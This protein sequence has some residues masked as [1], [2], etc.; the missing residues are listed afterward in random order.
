MLSEPSSILSS[1]SFR[2]LVGPERQEFAIHLEL[3]ASQSEVLD[4]LV[5]GNMKEAIA[6]CTTWENVDVQTFIRFG[7]Y[8]YTG[9]YEGESPLEPEPEPSI[10]G[11]EAHK[12][13]GVMDPLADDDFWG[14]TT[15]SKKK[16]KKKL[17]FGDKP[18]SF[19]TKREKTWYEFDNERSYDCGVAGIHLT[20]K[21]SDP[22]TRYKDVFLSHARVHMMAEYYGIQKL[23]Q[24]ALHKLHRTLC[25]FELHDE[26][27][28]DIVSLLRYC[29]KEDERVQ[30]R[31][32]VAMYSV[33]HFEKLWQNEEFRRLLNTYA[34]LSVAVLS[35]VLVR[36]D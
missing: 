29:F 11:E 34:E 21:N 23:S 36:V 8:V 12:E 33:C 27:V 1:K 32:L 7:Q 18:T 13:D 14:F 2:F 5:K 3:V 15:T 16:P 20:S 9:N 17:V 10:K 25:N 26:R 31:E 30:L 22:Q 6:G 28:D 4:R 24:L 19:L 35:S